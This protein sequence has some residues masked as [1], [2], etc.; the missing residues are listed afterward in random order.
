MVVPVDLFDRRP[1][2]YVLCENVLVAQKGR[3]L[4][5]ITISLRHNYQE[6]TTYTCMVCNPLL[7]ELPQV[8]DH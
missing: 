4:L 8:L 5:R 6:N 7:L 3:S 2:H 1:G